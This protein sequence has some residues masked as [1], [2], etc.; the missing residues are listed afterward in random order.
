VNA[1]EDRHAGQ[2]FLVVSHGVV[3]RVLLA[4]WT[5][6][7]LRDARRILQDNGAF[8]IVALEGGRANVI[9]LNSA[10]LT[11][12]VAAPSSRWNSRPRT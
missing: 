3:N 12:S 6:T 4:H 11:S 5:G 2:T 8:N 1:L 7:S 10:P 9:T